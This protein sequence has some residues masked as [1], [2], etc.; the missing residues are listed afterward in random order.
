MQTEDKPLA[1]VVKRFCAL[2]YDAFLLLALLLLATLPVVLLNQGEAIQNQWLFR[3]YLLGI[4]FF[5][6]AWQWRHGG[7][8]LAMVTWRFKVVSVD[9]KPIT[10]RQCALRFMTGAFGLSLFTAYFNKQRIAIHDYCSAT[11]C[12]VVNKNNDD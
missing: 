9:D 1:N 6:Y 12:V 8:T 4:L 7:Q 10:W 2:V 11:R 3:L 5:Y